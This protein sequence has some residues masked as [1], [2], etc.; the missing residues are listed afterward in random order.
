MAFDVI[1]SL[2]NLII[3]MT[4]FDSVLRVVDDTLKNAARAG[5]KTS[6]HVNEKIEL[7]IQMLER[8]HIEYHPGRVGPNIRE[9]MARARENDQ[10][11]STIRNRLNATFRVIK[12]LRL[13][14]VAF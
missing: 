4:I 7:A 8:Y 10:F 12:E 2:L 13:R 14:V 5:T 3:L 9:R 1:Y 11:S 6:E